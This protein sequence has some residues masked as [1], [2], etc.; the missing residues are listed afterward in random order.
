MV[1]YPETGSD[2]P[3]GWDLDRGRDTNTIWFGPISS[4]STMGSIVG[5]FWALS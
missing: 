5:P 3:I 1:S 4:S 2:S